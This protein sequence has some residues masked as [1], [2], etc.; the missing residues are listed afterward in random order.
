MGT[1][2][3]FRLVYS[4]AC[5]GLV[6][7]WLRLAKTQDAHWGSSIR[8]WMQQSCRTRLDKCQPCFARLPQRATNSSLRT[9]AALEPQRQTTPPNT[10]HA[11]VPG[12]AFPV[13]QPSSP[14]PLPVC[15]GPA[16]PLLQGKPHRDLVFLLSPLQFPAST[17]LHKPSADEAGFWT[18]HFDFC[19]RLHVLLNPALFLCPHLNFATL[20]VHATLLYCYAVL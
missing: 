4:C 19:T 14:S 17:P 12:P 15:P 7:A 16:Q 9:L 20:I 18:T 1:H 6:C 13:T 11:S 10:P 3:L 5:P 8:I 2:L